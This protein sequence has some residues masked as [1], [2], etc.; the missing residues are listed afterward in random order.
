MPWKTEANLYF[1]VIT[2][3]ELYIYGD[4]Y[5]NKNRFECSVALKCLKLKVKVRKI[6]KYNL[7]SLKVFHYRYKVKKKNNLQ[8]E[9]KL[10]RLQCLSCPELLNW[11]LFFLSTLF[12]PVLGPE[13]AA[14]LIPKEPPDLSPELSRDNHRPQ[15]WRPSLSPSL[16]PL[17]H[18]NVF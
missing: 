13:L 8:N 14:K 1:A 12:S 10:P 17:Q 3:W 6:E 2:K 7:A 16:H 18:R 5:Q 9:T 4:F 15:C 11:L